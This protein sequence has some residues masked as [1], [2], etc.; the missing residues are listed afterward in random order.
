MNRG[1]AIIEGLIVVMVLAIVLSILFVVS[2]P[3]TRIKEKADYLR[4]QD[5]IAISNAWQLRTVSHANVPLSAFWAKL[6][7]GKAMM[8]GLD[9]NLGTNKCVKEIAGYIDLN[10]LVAENFLP[11]LPIN[12]SKVNNWTTNQ[13]G[14]YIQKN[15]DKTVTIGSCEVEEGVVL[16]I[17]R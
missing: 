6:P 8:I 17:T 5:M 10:S 16:E 7:D 4:V 11:S 12:P 15:V 1:S 2:N 3:L 14:Y 13:T 9:A